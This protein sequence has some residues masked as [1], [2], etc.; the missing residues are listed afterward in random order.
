MKHIRQAGN[1][2]NL[3]HEKNV[4]SA[5]W[6]AIKIRNWAINSEIQLY[7]SNGIVLE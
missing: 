7:L 6:I 2:P 5:N 4:P 3:L 1:L